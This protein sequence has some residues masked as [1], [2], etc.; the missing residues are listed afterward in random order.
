MN[1]LKKLSTLFATTA[2]RSSAHVYPLAVQCNRYGE[3]I[4]T[5]INLNN[6]L[7]VEYDTDGNATTYFCRQVLIGKQRCYQPIEVTLTFD[8]KRKLM[9]RKITDGRF[10]EHACQ[11]KVG[12]QASACIKRGLK[13]ALRG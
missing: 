7:S 12:V 4:R 13:A 8:A 2:R 3:V 5:Q 10:V 9:D 6:D 1:L 11:L